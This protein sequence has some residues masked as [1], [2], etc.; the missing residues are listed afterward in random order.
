MFSKR[1]QHHFRNSN[2]SGQSEPF[3]QFDEKS[4]TVLRRVL[5]N[6][7]LAQGA[8]DL[9]R[10]HNGEIGDGED[11]GALHSHADRNRRRPGELHRDYPMAGV[12]Q[13]AENGDQDAV[14]KGGEEEI[15]EGGLE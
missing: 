2:L 15:G 3:L 9:Q 8:D 5:P 4:I 13:T 7:H 12:A 14:A 10:N 6:G 11:H 1:L